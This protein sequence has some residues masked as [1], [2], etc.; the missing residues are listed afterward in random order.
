MPTAIRILFSC[1]LLIFIGINPSS[2]D[3]Y[4]QNWSGRG[5]GP[6]ITGRVTGTVIDS[7][8][9][10][11]VEFATVALR[12]KDSEE[13]VDGMISSE[14]GHFK[15]TEIK[16]GSYDLVVSFIGYR[17]KTFRAIT[18]T[19]KK[20][21][22]NAGDVLLTKDEVLLDQVE[23]TAEAAVIENKIDRIVYNADKDASTV[24]GDA[25]DVL[26]KVPMLSVD[27]E[28]NVSLR[29]SQNVRILLNGK[30][31][32]MFSNNVADALKMFPADQIKSVEV[33]TTP[34]A[35]YDAEGTGGIINIV[36]K[37]KSVEGYNATIN[38]AVGTRQNRGSLSV[39]AGKGRFGMN[40]S[41]NLYYSIPQDATR[42]FYREDQVNG[43]TR[44]LDQSGITESSRL[45]F[46]GQAGA[47]YDFNAYN[48]INSSFSL[49]GHSFDQDGFQDARFLDPLVELDQTYRR[50]N[51]AE[52][53]RSGYDWTT[54]YKRTFKTPNQEL[55]FGFQLNGNVSDDKSTIRQHGNDPAVYANE[56]LLNDG[57]NLES[58]FQIDYVHPFS[59]SLKWEVGAKS[60]FRDID[61]DYSYDVFD[62]DRSEYVRDQN[63]SNM[64]DYRQDVYAGYTSFT[65]QMGKN[66]GLVAGGRYERTSIQGNFTNEG[67]AFTN[68]YDNFAPSIIVSRKFGFNTLKVSYAKRIRRPSLFYIN[69]FVNS[70]DRRNVTFGNPYLAPEI[71]NQ[72]DIG[73]TSFNKGTVISSSVYYRRTNDVIQSLLNVDQVG[74]SE[75]SYQNI[76]INDAVGV[77]LFTSFALKK[78]WTLRS[79]FD[80]FSFTA[81]SERLGLQNSGVQFKVFV[82]S[83]FNLQKGWKADVFGFANSPRQ[84]LQGK[85]PSFSMMSLGIKKEILKK[86]GSVGIT[87]VDPFN[88]TKRFKSE[89]EGPTF[90]QTTDFRLPFR[91]FGINFS[92]TFGKLDFKTRKRGSKIKNTDLKQGEGDG[93]QGGGS[94][95]N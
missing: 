67:S 43:T 16:M 55:S 26:R 95:Q 85:V 15:L 32:G 12:K 35:K 21:D 11:P 56:N 27:L 70:S 86:K 83:S 47:F 5:Q 57:K 58:T 78:F 53:L 49:R 60:V 41:G 66:Y 25:A 19:P 50:E 13:A 8:S 61:S 45:G 77:N 82:N 79:N 4:A 2:R 1:F 37:K 63:R 38:G 18:L 36:T 65:I 9:G 87:I 44:I 20:P 90:F 69:P 42:T 10:E 73:Y 74:I 59:K 24:G 68:K 40:G 72:F 30:P 84:T 33:I 23:V 71:S 31:S 81:K 89:L 39:N 52:N 92:Y 91:S 94:P 54:D 3:L 14:K 93:G 17:T 46:W 75:T 29:G 34:G 28:G 48:S 80:V 62:D 6:S 7:L 76:G 22:F 64:F 51:E 88:E